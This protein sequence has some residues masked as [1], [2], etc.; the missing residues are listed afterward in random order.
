MVASFDVLMQNFYKVT[1]GNHE[2]VPSFATRLEGTLNQIQLKCP[3]WIADCEVSWHLKDHLFH[4]VHKHIRDSIRYLYSNPETTYSQLM[5]MAY[6]AESEM[7]EA[8][9]KVRARSAVTTEVIDRS[10]ELSNQ[11]AKLMSALTR[12]EQGNYPASAPNSPRH[13]G[14]ERGWMDRN[15][16]T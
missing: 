2:K 8:K 1:Q 5:V 7:E 12:A 3:R 11:I 14:H 15:T 16:P 10:K 6:K 13:R 4:R 9:D